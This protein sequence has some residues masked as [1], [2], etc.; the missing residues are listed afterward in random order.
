MP[1]GLQ[2]GVG[3]KPLAV[4]LEK[5]KLHSNTSYIPLRD[6]YMHALKAIE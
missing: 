3:L 6:L 1:K 2:D 4:G 5:T